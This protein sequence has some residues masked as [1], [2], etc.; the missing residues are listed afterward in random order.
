MTKEP[1]D[2]R[3]LKQQATLKQVSERELCQDREEWT[4]NTCVK[5]QSS[6]T[7]TLN[8]A[9]QRK[10]TFPQT[11]Q[12]VVDPV[13]THHVD[14]YAHNPTLHRHKA[15]PLTVGSSCSSRR[16]VSPRRRTKHRCSASHTPDTPNPSLLF[17]AGKVLP[18]LSVDQTKSLLSN[19]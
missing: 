3:R 17:S 10:G 19:A 14:T 11:E 15:D 12:S 2:V 6:Q 9:P 13:P 5:F 18:S 16:C 8:R 7:L 4:E 1:L